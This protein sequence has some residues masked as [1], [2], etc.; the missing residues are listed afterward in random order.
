[1]YHYGVLAWKIFTNSILEAVR[2]SYMHTVHF[3]KDIFIHL[4]PPVRGGFLQLIDET[5]FM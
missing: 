2:R 1:M 3:A 5:P 4:S